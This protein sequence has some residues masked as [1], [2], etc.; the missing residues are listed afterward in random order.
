[1]KKAFDSVV[2]EVVIEALSNQDTPTQYIKMLPELYSNF[3]TRISS[4]YKQVII[5]VKREVR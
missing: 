4:F 5:Y 1:M 2:T 3:T